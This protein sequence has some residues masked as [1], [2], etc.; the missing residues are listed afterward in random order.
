MNMGLSTF[1]VCLW[2]SKNCHVNVFLLGRRE[3]KGLEEK[4]FTTLPKLWYELFSAPRQ[5]TPSNLACKRPLLCAYN[6]GFR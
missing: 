4:T 2:G 5:N 6:V 1:E 3:D